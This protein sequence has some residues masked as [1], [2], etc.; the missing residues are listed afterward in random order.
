MSGKRR[1]LRK[2]KKLSVGV[3][4]ARAIVVVDK[5]GKE[6]F[7]VSCSVSASSPRVLLI[8]DG[9]LHRTERRWRLFVVSRIAT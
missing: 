7:T 5:S 9:A 6:P 4:Q 3:L 1:R 8:V 2:A